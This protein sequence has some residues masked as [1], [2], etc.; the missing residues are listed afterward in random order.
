MVV[1]GGFQLKQEQMN[2]KSERASNRIIQSI[3]L[4]YL[5]STVDGLILHTLQQLH[6]ETR[7]RHQVL[8]LDGSRFLLM[9]H[10]VRY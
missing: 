3:H 4:G 9:Y 7:L 8:E 10:T 6:R 2:H 5:D 1:D